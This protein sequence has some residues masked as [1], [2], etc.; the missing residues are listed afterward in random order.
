MFKLKIRVEALEHGRYFPTNYCILPIVLAERKKRRLEAR[1]VPD[2]ENLVDTVD[3]VHYIVI[4]L[5][6]SSYHSWAALSTLCSFHLHLTFKIYSASPGRGRHGSSVYLYRVFN[7][8]VPTILLA[9][10]DASGDSKY[11]I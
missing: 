4:L 3:R 6:H 1:C 9:T 11:H 2:I 7:S 10:N 8:K 5:L